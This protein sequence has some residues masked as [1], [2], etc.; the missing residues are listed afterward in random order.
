MKRRTPSAGIKNSPAKWSAKRSRRSFFDPDRTTDSS[1][2]W[3]SAC[4][5]S[6]ATVKRRRPGV[7]SR[8][9]RIEKPTPGWLR[10]APE[11]VD[12]R[13]APR[14]ARNTVMPSSSHTQSMSE[15]GPRP[16]W[17]RSRTSS[18]FRRA[19][20]A[21]SYSVREMNGDWIMPGM[22]SLA[23]AARSA[24]P[25]RKSVKS[26]TPGTASSGRS[27]FD[28]SSMRASSRSRV[29][30]VSSRSS[31]TDLRYRRARANSWRSFGRRA[32]L[33]Q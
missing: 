13:S 16:S 5:I 19:S 10:K 1:S 33:S 20:S 3:N 23:A 6:W 31:S 21:V 27:A 11:I 30:S 26:R 9:T 32:P 18:A 8:L 4:P 25:S 14:D 15:M 28:R 24:Y 29:M 7:M 2:L 22:S 17:S 12:V